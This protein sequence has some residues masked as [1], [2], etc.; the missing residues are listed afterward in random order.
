MFTIP[1]AYAQDWGGCVVNEGGAQVATLQCL[2][3][4]FR[5]LVN[6]AL[7]FVG[8]VAVI[9]LIYAGIRLTT[10]GG[11]P[12]QVQGARQIITYC[13]IGLILVLCS[14]GIIY[15]IAYLTNATCIEQFSF[16]NCM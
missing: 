7:I 1:P 3:I 9:L 2:P 16:T 14:F 8:S 5:N 10:S 13:I 15:L 6:A 4:V 11:D 12:K